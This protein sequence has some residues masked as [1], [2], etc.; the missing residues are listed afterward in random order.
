M[1]LLRPDGANEW[2][3]VSH[4]VSVMDAHHSESAIDPTQHTHI[5]TEIE[6]INGTI[7]YDTRPVDEIANAWNESALLTGVR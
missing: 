3:N 7:R 6:L 1:K 4:V 2:I 5:R